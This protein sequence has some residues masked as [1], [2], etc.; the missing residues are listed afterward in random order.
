MLKRY[1][2]MA[3]LIGLHAVKG[4]G[5]SNPDSI[6]QNSIHTVLIHPVNKPLAIPVVPLNGLSPLLISFDDFKNEYQ[7][8]YYSVELRNADWS[9]VPMSA[10]DYLQGFNQ[11]KISNFSVSSIATQRY[12]HYEFS[13]PNAQVRPTQSGNY[14]LKVFKNGNANE[15]VF[16]RRFFVTEDQVSI[17]ATVQE[18]FNA[19]ISKTHQKIQLVLDVKKIPFFQ[20]DQIKSTIIQ[21][22]RYNDALTLAAPAFIRGNLLEYNSEDQYI[23]PAGKEARWLDIQNLRL[24]S[25]RIA[26]INSKADRAVVSVKPDLSRASTA[27]YTFNDLNGNFI[28]SNTESLQSENQNDY[29]TVNFTYLPK[30][31]IPFIGH[32]L[33]LAGALTNNSLNKEAEMIFDPTLGYYKK[34]ILIKQGYYSYNYILREENSFNALNDFTET[35]GNH[36]ETEN[37]YSIMVYYRPPGARHDHIIGF[38]TINSRQNW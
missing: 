3:L 2:W 34:S 32:K 7:D 5:Q 10:F 38:G 26:E 8:Y 36:W 14:I 19:Q 18:P 9:A 4:H 31:K 33:Y 21:N 11:N 30:D 6:Y 1:L 15:L 23:F 28:I 25:D 24:R 20:T 29:A 35:E 27:Y 17:A 22:Y 12:Y 13:F 16:T 37:N